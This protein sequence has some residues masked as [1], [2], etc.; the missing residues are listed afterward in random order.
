MKR[1]EIAKTVD[2]SPFL[3]IT[4]VSQSLFRPCS[5][6]GILFEPTANI[7]KYIG[8]RG[9]L[10]L[11]LHKINSFKPNLLCDTFVYPKVILDG[12]QCFSG[13]KAS[14]SS[15]KSIALGIGGLR[16][17]ARMCATCWR[18]VDSREAGCRYPVT[19]GMRYLLHLVWKGPHD[20]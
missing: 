6:V 2:K 3:L 4:C 8:N 19:G 15:P 10:F 17:V 16:A 11:R 14:F 5:W 1:E 13:K 7:R 12:K 20:L 18:H 9:L